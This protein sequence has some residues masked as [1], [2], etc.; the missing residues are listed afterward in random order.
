MRSAIC[1]ICYRG[2]GI[3]NVLYCGSC[4]TYLC[5]DCLGEK[6]PRCGNREHFLS[7]SEGPI[8]PEDERELEARRAAARERVRRNANRGIKFWW[9]LLALLVLAVLCQITKKLG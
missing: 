9:V 6:C 1:G 3:I 5:G 2:F 8:R 4:N 7:G